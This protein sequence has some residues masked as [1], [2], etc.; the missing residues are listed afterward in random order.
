MSAGLVVKTIIG[1]FLGL[2][3]GTILISPIAVNVYTASTD[4][5][6]TSTDQS[7]VVLI[8]TFFVIA[9]MMVAVNMI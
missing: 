6:L 1:G 3:V 7:L 8:T 5:N 2:L 9:I 4:G